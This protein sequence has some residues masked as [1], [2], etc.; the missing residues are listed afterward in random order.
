MRKTFENDA[1]E[2]KAMTPA[3]LTQYVR[4]EVEKWAPVA[5]AAVK[6]E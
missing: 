4:N 2:T 1:I 3:E 5:R 6:A